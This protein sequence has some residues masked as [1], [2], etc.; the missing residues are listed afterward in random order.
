[1]NEIYKFK[2]TQ[3]TRQAFSG[4]WAFLRNKEWPWQQLLY[5]IQFACL[6]LSSLRRCPTIYS[7]A[8]L[9][10]SF[11]HKNHHG[12]RNEAHV[13]GRET[14]SH[15]LHLPHDKDCLY[16]EGN[17]YHGFQSRCQLQHVSSR[18]SRVYRA[19]SCSKMLSS[20]TS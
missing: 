10:H 16:G 7:L 8:V 12:W 13:G 14:Q 11:S 9:V 17:S 3:V 19:S 4:F 15:P 1:M 20:S 6:R 2:K 18:P 5:Q